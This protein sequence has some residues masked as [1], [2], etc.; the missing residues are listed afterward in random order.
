LFHHFEIPHEIP[1]EIAQSRVEFRV[2]FQNDETKINHLHFEQKNLSFVV[3]SDS[4]LLSS[5]TGLAVKN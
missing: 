1:H 3:G 5:T 4:C 2:E